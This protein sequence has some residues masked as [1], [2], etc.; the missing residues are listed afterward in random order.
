[1]E[2][3][4]SIIR[5]AREEKGYSI[6]QVARETNIAKRYIVAL[7]SED[8]EAFPGET[9]FIGFLRNYAEFLGEDPDRLIGIF[10]NM[11][12]Q[13]QP[14][15]M[16]EL[17]TTR[18]RKGLPVIIAAAAVLAVLGVIFW[19]RILPGMEERSTLADAEASAAAEAPA[20]AA[21]PDPSAPVAAGSRYDF[22][23]EILERSFLSG[24]TIVVYSAGGQ[25]PLTVGAIGET[26]TL[27]G[28]SGPLELKPEV[29]SLLDLNGDG[30][31]DV[32]ILLRRI[33]DDR[34]S[35]VLY[36]DKYVESADPLAH[37]PDAIAPAATAAAP[38]P[39]VPAAVPA[40]SAVIGTASVASR[41]SREVVL[42]VA[43][44]PES[45]DL[46]VVFRGLCLLRYVSDANTREERYF[47]KSEVFKLEASRE[48]RLWI[49]NAGSFTGKIRGVD[50]PLGNPGEVATKLIRWEKDNGTGKYQL[51]LIPVY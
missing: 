48:M 34:S 21:R 6:E 42:L 28:G 38:E 40:T 15:P 41:A 36:L 19:V 32:K 30:V 39:A 43:D 25:F 29:S 14:P 50:V 9:Y 51:K 27:N 37:T 49:S 13:E 1:M 16:E 5:T 33:L 7:E 12:I 26:V 18:K 8:V 46:D 20:P 4:G 45:F 47:H 11:K 10:R 23:D 24:D 22:K 17:L 2:S 35:V 31:N 3:I 44:K